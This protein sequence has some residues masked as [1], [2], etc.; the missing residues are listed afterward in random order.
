MSDEPIPAPPGGDIGQDRSQDRKAGYR[1]MPSY[2]QEA[3]A[4]K[5]REF[6][7]GR[8]AADELAKRRRA[9]GHAEGAPR[10]VGYWTDDRSFTA[11]EKETVD[12]K[13]AANDLK[14]HRQ[15]DA[16]DK[17]LTDRN[18]L[19]NKIDRLR[20][21]ANVPTIIDHNA[22]PDLENPDPRLFGDLAYEQPTEPSQPQIEPGPQTEQD[23]L[24]QA[25][26]NPK[27]RSAVEAEVTKAFELQAKHAQQIQVANDFALG[28][29]R[30]ALPEL[31]NVRPDQVVQFFNQMAQTNPPRFK[32][33]MALL[34]NVAKTQAA[35][36]QVE[37]QR[38]HRE[39]QEFQ[40]YA[41]EQ[42]AAFEKRVGSQTL[43][44]RQAVAAEM[45]EYAA[46]FGVN[47]E[48]LT[49]ILATNPLARHAG[50]Q[51]MMRDAAL[52]RIARKNFEAQR[53]QTRAANVPHV[54]QPGHSNVGRHSAQSAHLQA[55]SAKLSQS[56]SAKDAAALLL[57]SRNARKRG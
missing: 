17:E 3:P 28:A 25:F 26:Q 9:K 31:A 10:P 35:R 21:E 47:R 55:L 48:T 51:S 38:Q 56:G 32:Q 23:H 2:K 15:V 39:R 40:A 50:F 19:A 18:D 42:D 34:N 11:P 43:Q 14:A 57:A 41:K 33:A 5:E 16:I 4:T 53:Q 46:E 20:K 27:I 37:Q 1:E 44:Q 24:A 7:T 45:V 52:G 22:P 30:S 12:L 36:Q 8:E 54:Q 6:S 49:N 13:R 29:L